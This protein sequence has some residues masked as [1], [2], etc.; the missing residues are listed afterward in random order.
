MLLFWRNE[1][2]NATMTWWGYSHDVG[3]GQMAWTCVNIRVTH[4][5]YIHHDVD[6]LWPGR[7]KV[8]T[9]RDAC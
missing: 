6:K 7:G 8:M 9:E 3:K 1:D 4:D 5:I 2:F